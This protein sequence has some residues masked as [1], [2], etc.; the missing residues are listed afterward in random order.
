[1]TSEETEPE[2]V[3]SG[4]WAVKLLFVVGVVALLLWL[5]SR[6]SDEVDELPFP[7]DLVEGGVAIGGYDL[8][9]PGCTAPEDLGGVLRCATETACANRDC[10]CHLFSRDT[11]DPP[12]DPDSWRHEAPPDTEVRERPGRAYRCFCV[13]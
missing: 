4:N 7:A 12:Q 6:E 13:R 5:R 1:M 11:D 9:G 3:S 2:N 10:A 8:C